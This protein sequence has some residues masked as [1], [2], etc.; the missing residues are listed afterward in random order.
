[1]TSH[2]VGELLKVDEEGKKVLF[3]QSHG[4]AETKVAVC[5]CVCGL[6]GVMGE[7]GQVGSASERKLTHLHTT[8]HKHTHTQQENQSPSCSGRKPRLF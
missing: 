6:G 4:Q 3:L 7:S 1:M 5:V 8:T 2:S